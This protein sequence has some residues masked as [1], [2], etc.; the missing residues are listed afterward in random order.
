V[1]WVDWVSGRT[2]H[3][4]TGFELAVA[5]A[6]DAGSVPGY[7]LTTAYCNAKRSD[8]QSLEC[9]SGLV[10]AHGA[11]LVGVVGHRFSAGLRGGSLFY[12]LHGVP[13]VSPTSTG[14]EH[15]SKEGIE[16]VFRVRT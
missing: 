7:T 12:N 8:L 6:Q 9:A 13:L 1:D 3:S 2:G 5:M 15:I 11:D 14:S 4:R 10:A 16:N